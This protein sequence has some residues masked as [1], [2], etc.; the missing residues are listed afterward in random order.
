MNNNHKIILAFVLLLIAIIVI[1]SNIHLFNDEINL[2]GTAFEVVEADIWIN[3]LNKEEFI[4]DKNVYENSKLLEIEKLYV[5]ILPVK[6]SNAVT[7]TEINEQVPTGE[8]EVINDAQDLFSNIYFEI[9]TPSGIVN[10]ET[11]PNAYIEIR[12]QSS[13]LFEQ[14]SYKIKIAD[15]EELWHEYKTINLNKHMADITRIKNKL[16]F[17][18]LQTLDDISS[19]NTKFITMYIKDLSKQDQDK[20]Y[21]N[22]GLYT[23]VEQP[24]KR[25]L[26]RHGLD[27]NGHFYKVEDFE[28][29]R[30]EESI[31]TIEEIDYS[32]EAFEK[33]LET[34]GS[35]E[36]SKLIKMLYELNNISIDIDKIIGKYFDKDNMF[37][38]LA[39]NILF[40]NFDTTT[41]N[42]LIYSPLNSRKW[43]FVPWDYDDSMRIEKPQ[44]TWQTGV[45]LYWLSVLF[46]RTFKEQHNI[47]ELTKKVEEIYADIEAY[48]LNVKIDQYKDVVEEHVLKMPDIEYVDATI[49]EYNQAYEDIKE[50]VR[51]NYDE[52]FEVLERPMPFFYGLPIVE[53]NSVEFIWEQSYDLQN[54]SV[55]YDFY[56]AKDIS[57]NQVIYTSL[58]NRVPKV[59]VDDLQ[60]G[61]YYWK[62]YAK[63]EKGNTGTAF[64]YIQEDNKYYFG[65]SVVYYK[66]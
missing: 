64:D 44:D 23:F 38:W 37:T 7:F 30:H 59:V 53:E 16:I 21:V 2:E 65:V 27:P 29:L 18:Y 62:V 17:D 33:R 13:R 57:M 40:D 14:K 24:N 54:E 8:D 48:D 61:K 20:D 49:T 3:P 11:K 43:Y 9:S 25:Y 52:Y 47:D 46:K 6:N 31:K 1:T 63:D 39:I 26:A 10:I 28:F 50:S 36:H 12:G 19:Y 35:T 60:P 15:G 34:R 56:L 55:V 41:R 66:E 45:S 32:E 4:E 5:T 58:D 22:Y 42:Y 51:K